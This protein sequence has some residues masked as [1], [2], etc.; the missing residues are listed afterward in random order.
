MILLAT[1][2]ITIGIS[3]AIFLLIILLLVTILLYAKKKLLPQ[4]NVHIDVNS[5]ETIE[6]S[7]GSSLL[8]TLSG[9][10]IFLPSA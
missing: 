5:E 2:W 1:E 6:V 8:V 10:K 9:Q 3:M 7:P 4:G